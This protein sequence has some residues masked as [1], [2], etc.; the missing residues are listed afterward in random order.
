MYSVPGNYYLRIHHIRPRFKN[1]V[2]NVLLYMAQECAK[3]PDG[4]VAEYSK[5]F[6][7]AIMLY[8]GN[9]SKELK[10]INNW[11]TE[12]SSLFGFYI[13]DKQQDK[14]VTGKVAKLLAKQQDLIQFFKYYLLTFQYPGGHLKAHEI[15][16][17]TENGVKFK[18]AK[19]IASL[20]ICGNERLKDSGKLFSI[21]KAEA[22]HC[23][24]NDLRVT[25]DN[26]NPAEVLDLIMHN[27]THKVDYDT[28]GD[29]IRYAGDILDYMVL[30]N[31]LRENHGYYS[32]NGLEAETI[33][34]LIISDTWFDGYD[35][36]YER[37]YELHEIEEI[38]HNWFE[39]VNA[40]VDPHSFNTDISEFV[41]ESSPLE[42]SE[43]LNEKI[44]G[45]FTLED[46]RTKD[47]GDIGETLV[48][49]HEK[50]RAIECGLKDFIHLIKKIPTSYAVGY[51]IQSLEGTPDKTKRYIEVKSTISKN[52]L[53]YF[54]VHLTT[55]EWESASTLKEHYFI[56]RLMI[57]T[58]EMYLYILKDP[59][60]MY[61][62]D[63]ITMIPRDGADLGFS[64]DVCEKVRLKIWQQ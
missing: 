52:K 42:Y 14:T 30:A 60:S 50:M 20:L 61:K 33:S 40:N 11:R 44:L 64:E 25:R 63:K 28:R 35:E 17:L 51:D 3:I 45:L 54:S 6:N 12:I 49:G 21:T 4:T 32:L 10:T 2:E 23:I 53:H 26:R 34:S 59:V 29:I 7:K 24:F 57:S 55:N 19:Y 8:P 41:K 16:P 43:V 62:N 46:V 1:D 37:P 56:Y 9:E 5:S 27:R 15:K 13:E 22:A 31:L 39:Y 38:R 36:F 18:P 58:G 48:V 47:I